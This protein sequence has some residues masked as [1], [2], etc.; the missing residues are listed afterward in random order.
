[1]RYPSRKADLFDDPR[2]G[3]VG[4]DGADF[5]THRIADTAVNIA[6]ICYQRVEAHR[7]QDAAGNA[8]DLHLMMR[9]AQPGAQI[10]IEIMQQI[11]GPPGAASAFQG[12]ALE[13]AGRDHGG[14]RRLI[15]PADTAV[16]DIGAGW[17]VVNIRD[18]GAQPAGLLQPPLFL[19]PL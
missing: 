4:K 15:E 1:M 10:S 19:K 14:T 13:D 11:A 9:T 3:A 17:A 8:V 12:E 6:D 5:Q 7:P 18:E 2:Q 16:A